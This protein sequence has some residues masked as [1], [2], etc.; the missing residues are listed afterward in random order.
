[1]KNQICFLVFVLII[2]TS[3][4]FAQQN[5]QSAQK[6]K[7]LTGKFEEITRF[8]LRDT[9]GYGLLR[10]VC[11]FGNRLSGSETLVKVEDFF[12]EKLKSMGLD[13]VYTQSTTTNNWKRG[14]VGR[15]TPVQSDEKFTIAAVGGSVGTNGVIKTKVIEVAGFDDLEAKKDQVKGKIV[16]Y[17]F[18]FPQDVYDSFESYGP[19]GAYRWMGAIR[20]AKYG[21]VGVLIRSVASNF[22][23]VPHTGSLGY[24]DSIPKIP[25]AALGVISAVKLSKFLSDPKNH[26]SD[27][28]FEMD[29]RTEEP[30]TVRNII[31][32]IKGSE[33]PDE[34]IVVGGHI[35]SWDVGEGAHDDG[36]GIVQAVETLHLIKKA[37]IKPKRTIRAVLFAN[38]ENGLAGGRFYGKSAAEEKVTHIAAIE[39]DRGG[40]SPRGFSVASSPEV[41]GKIQAWLPYF[42][43]TGIEWIQEGRDGADVSQIKNC[44]AIIGFVPDSQRYFD[45]HHSANDIFS[46]VNNRELELGSAAITILTVLISEFGL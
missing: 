10:Q 44:S 29:C 12:I 21:A 23:D 31:G 26:N 6:D 1:M 43:R 18:A 25:A 30:A 46:A 8:A 7:V 3:G 5:P 32:E 45:I 2:G 24:F 36:A 9:F 22:D 27:F 28:E 16:F 19:T 13:S 42:L 33:F 37:G 14:S 20:A 17:N 34:V 35:D 38:E 11:S 15:F 41:L 39:S 4:I 40:F